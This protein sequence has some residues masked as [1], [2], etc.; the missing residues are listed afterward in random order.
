MMK[1]CVDAI[2]AWIEAHY[3]TLPM[4]WPNEDW[5]AD[6]QDPQETGSAFVEVEIIGGT[7]YIRA[8]SRPGNRVW[9]HPGLIRFYIFQ[10]LNTG[11][12]T[13]LDTADQ[14]AAFME[15]TEFGQT[16][17]GKMVRTLDFSTYANVAAEESGNFFV[18][19]SSVPFDFYYTN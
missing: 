12:D 5:P 7:N 4:R 18:L 19:I 8:F 14:L 13:A 16:P 6:I 10:P 9:I 1:P 17:D 3:S 2:R 11:M 15:R